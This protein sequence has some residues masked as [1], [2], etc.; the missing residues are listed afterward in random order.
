MRKDVECTFGILKKRWRVLNNGFFY[1]DIN[2]CEKIFV[3]CCCLNNF[4]VDQMERSN[5]RVGCGGPI[6]DDGIWLDGH[7]SMFT[8]ATDV[9]MLVKFVKI[10]SLL[11]KHLYVFR[12]KGAI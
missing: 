9:A 7:T 5:I 8:N 3:T 12:Q 11:A 4:L 10:R 2:I 1:R 6:G